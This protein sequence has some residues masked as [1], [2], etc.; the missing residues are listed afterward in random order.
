MANTD[1]YEFEIAGDSGF[2]AP[3]VG[4][5]EDHFFTRNTRATLK[6]TVPN[7]TYF[8][9]IRAVTKSGATSP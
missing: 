6:K 7:G 5:G 8:W 9:R 1:R 2:N 3:V 4:S